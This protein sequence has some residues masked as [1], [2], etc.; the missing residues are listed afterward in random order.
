[1][2]QDHFKGCSTNEVAQK[3]KLYLGGKAWEHVK[4]EYPQ[5]LRLKKITIEEMR[6]IIAF[7]KPYAMQVVHD[8]RKLGHKIPVAGVIFNRFLWEAVKY[9]M[10]NNGI[11]I[12][13]GEE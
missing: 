7:V 6:L 5:L 1:M 12:D 2:L 10:V 3:I 9:R 8:A 11:K 13:R 4:R